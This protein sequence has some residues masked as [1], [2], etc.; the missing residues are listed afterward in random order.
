MMQQEATC[1]SCYSDFSKQP[2]PEC[3]A[4]RS[5]RVVS[6]LN[7]SELVRDAAQSLMWGL[8]E[9]LQ[10][11]CSVLFVIYLHQIIW[12]HNV[13][14]TLFLTF[15][16]SLNTLVFVRF[17]FQSI[18]SLLKNLHLVLAPTLTCAV[19]NCLLELCRPAGR[20]KI[21][22]LPVSGSSLP[23]LFINTTTVTGKV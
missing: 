19:G 21:L 10:V 5:S 20:I 23:Q 14:Q 16:M 1:I 22:Q 9:F 12:G 18:I 17:D 8:D 4:Q 11:I 13:R 15:R 3:T 2:C 7:V 6:V